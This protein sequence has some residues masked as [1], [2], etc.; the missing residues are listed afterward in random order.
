[1]RVKM[2]SLKDIFNENDTSY[3]ENDGIFFKNKFYGIVKSMFYLFDTVIEIDETTAHHVTR[4]NGF[5]VKDDDTYYIYN[6]YYINE[7][8]FTVTG[9]SDNID[10]MFDELIQDIKGG[11]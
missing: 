2:K 5:N 4:T 10:K 6:D 7:N 9:A 1:M 8:W 3:K 11:D